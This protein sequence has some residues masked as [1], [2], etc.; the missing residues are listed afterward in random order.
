[1][2]VRRAVVSGVGCVFPAGAG[3]TLDRLDFACLPPPAEVQLG[4]GKRL[5]HYPVPDLAGHPHHPDRKS[6]RYMRPDAIHAVIAASL[7]LENAGLAGANHRDTLFYA[8]AGQCYADMWPFLRQGVNESLVNDVFNLQHFGQSGFSRINPFFAVR[9]LAALP[10]AFVAE[11]YGIHGENF[12]LS[13][14][15]AESAEP[16]RAAM[17]AIESGQ[18]TVALVGGFGYLGNPHEI[19]NL[20][21]TGFYDGDFFG[22][23]SA[24][25]I[26]IEDLDTCK[27]R[28]G[29]P[30]ANLTS[31]ATKSLAVHEECRIDYHAS[32]WQNLLP[33][34]S[35]ADRVV[36]QGAGTEANHLL[37]AAA[38][39]RLFPE[40]SLVDCFKRLGTLLAGAEP[41]GTALLALMLTQGERGVSLSRSITGIEA[42]VCLSREIAHG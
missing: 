24:T 4:G 40:A 41:F 1:M 23:S 12:V 33:S 29:T 18:A 19:E 2:T 21:G 17:A 22:S 25:F 14:F 9:T 32:I 15:G 37:E 34:L 31:I 8:A 13:S 26:V 6:C 16:I 38:A 36:F 7:A 10:M 39:R 3:S 30:L 28:K 5:F 35:P 42:A 20:Y 27:S 11:K